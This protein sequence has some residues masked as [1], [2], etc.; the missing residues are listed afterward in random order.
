MSNKKLDQLIDQLENHLE[1]WKQF[2]Y[3]LGLA[4]SKQ[5][6]PDDESHFLEVKSLITQE[7]ELIH[8]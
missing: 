2:N 6:D 8:S 3:Y 7:L 5:F 4:R 1:C